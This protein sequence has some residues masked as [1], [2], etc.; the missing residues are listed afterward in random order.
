MAGHTARLS[1]Q[2]I[3]TDVHP[4]L[5]R[6]EAIASV[7]ERSAER[8]KIREIRRQLNSAIVRICWTQPSSSPLI[9][10]ACMRY[11]SNHAP[12]E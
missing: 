2:P 8:E 6:W 1:A 4:F 3:N 10:P 5:K 12:V 11:W 7:L 9:G